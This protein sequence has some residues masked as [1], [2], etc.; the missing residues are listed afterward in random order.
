MPKVTVCIPIYGVE[1]YIERCARSLF[2]QTLD[3][4][5]FIFVNDCTPDRSIEILER[6]I[7]E[8]RLRIVE[9][10]YKVRIEQMPANSGQA[11]VRRHGMLCATGDYVIH[12]DSDD[13]VD[14][15]MYQ[16]MYDTIVR[17]SADVVICDYN[18]TNG[19]LVTERVRSC[20]SSS[21]QQFAENILFIKES[22]S[23]WNKL[24]KRSLYS[25]IVYPKGDMGEDMVI[26]Y[27][28]MSNSQTLVYIPE[29]YY[30]YYYN[31]ESITNHITKEKLIRNYQQMV[32]NSR[33]ILS[34]LDHIELSK[35]MSEGIITYKNY[36]RS[37][38][39]PL[40]S[41]IHYYQVWKDVFPELNK[42]VLCSRNISCFEKMRVVLTILHMFPRFCPLKPVRI[43]CRYCKL[44]RSCMGS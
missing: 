39:Y 19:T 6:L 26:V 33:I 17:E 43:F 7:E 1:K 20:D 32:D 16:K 22:W 35:N 4:I 42:Q 29:A 15:C 18:I 8:Y 28:L 14:V 11:A 34:H 40:V 2:E 12:C 9:K 5:E 38:L 24:F 30:Y 27:Q 44:E 25:N 37:I 23:L 13:W 10:N 31:P 36:V 41:D 21:P 3:D